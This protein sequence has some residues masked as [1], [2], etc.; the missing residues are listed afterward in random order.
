MNSI[1]EFISFIPFE[2]RIII[3]SG[4]VMYIGLAIKEF[5]DNKKL[6]QRCQN[7]IQE[8]KW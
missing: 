8:R 6:C 5:K 3:L 1:A 7:E 2:V 4:V